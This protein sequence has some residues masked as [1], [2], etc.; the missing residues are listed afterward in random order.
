[1][2]SW[3]GAWLFKAQYALL[4]APFLLGMRAF[5][6]FVTLG[7]CAGGFYLLGAS[8]SGWGWPTIWIHE[9]VLPFFERDVVANLHHFTTIRGAV[10]RASGTP[11]LAFFAGA[12]LLGLSLIAVFLSASRYRN[13]DRSLIYLVALL[14]ALAPVISLHGLFYDAALLLPALAVIASSREP[15]DYLFVSGVVLLSWLDLLS[16][17]LPVQPTMVITLVVVLRLV[18]CHSGFVAT[19][20]AD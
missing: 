12:I 18:R 15:K 7:I 13:S 8:V 14:G 10:L 1:M 20:R 11:S 9:G 4:F 3:I 16:K 17:A 19:H 5:K 6:S 2:G